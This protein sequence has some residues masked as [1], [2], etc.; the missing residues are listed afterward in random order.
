MC[1]ALYDV[2]TFYRC[3]RMKI[4]EAG[5][6]ITTLSPFDLLGSDEVGLSKALAYVMGREPVALYLFLHYVGITTQNTSKNFRST[7]IEVERVRDEGRTDIEIRQPGKFHVIIEAKVKSNKVKQQ[8]TQ[9]LQ[10]F[11]NEHKKVLCFITGM[12][13]FKKAIH[14]EIEIHNLGWLEILGLFDQPKFK[15]HD[16]I[17]DFVEFMRKGFSVRE[18]K[19]ILIQDVGNNNE[20]RRFRAFQ[21]YRRDV[22]FGSPLYFSPYFTRNAKQQEGEGI[23]YLSRIMGI[24]SMKPQSVD[25][26]RDDLF[27]FNGNNEE[28]TDRWIRGVRSINGPSDAERV[29]TYFFLDEP[30]KLNNPLKKGPRGRGHNKDW[31][32]SQIPRNRCV[33]F[34]E[35]A[36]K[37]VAAETNT[38]RDQREDSIAI[39]AKQGGSSDE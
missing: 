8:R 30:L 7:S 27:K 23:F 18:Q 4:K 17:R 29:F 38:T 28:L 2:P 5:I 9:Y 3:S 19:E 22:V 32:G 16:L 10:S 11:D 12:N 34:L 20:I 24:L 39:R 15:S 14:N 26:F 21:V 35:F 33:S 1:D 13:D 37:M 31:I 6:N 25:N 36:R